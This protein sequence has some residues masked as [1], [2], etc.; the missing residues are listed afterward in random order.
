[1]DNNLTK[2][3][4]MTGLFVFHLIPRWIDLLQK[5][6]LERS[7]NIKFVEDRHLIL[8]YDPELSEKHLKIT[9]PQIVGDLKITFHG[10]FK[11]YNNLGFDIEITS[12]T[13]EDLL[14]ASSYKVV[15]IRDLQEALLKHHIK[16]EHMP[17]HI[18][19]N[20]SLT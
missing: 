6:I 3:S 2:D 16:S 5:E 17:L 1:M 11:E 7:S 13:E 15:L 10:Y 18:I 12:T 19:N 8:S 9:L 20:N 4:V 14:F